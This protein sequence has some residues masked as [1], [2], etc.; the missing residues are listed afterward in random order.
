MHTRA[1]GAPTTAPTDANARCACARQRAS[2]SDAPIASPAA[3]DW[4]STYSAG[5]V[6]RQAAA[7]SGPPSGGALDAASTKR[8]EDMAGL[9]PLLT[10]SNNKLCAALVDAF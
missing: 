2:S 3:D 8:P 7:D 9:S 1:A 5:A 4:F 10:P 6:G